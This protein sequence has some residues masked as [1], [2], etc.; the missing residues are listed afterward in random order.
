MYVPGYGVR[1]VHLVF[2]IPKKGLARFFANDD[3]PG[4]LV[5]N[6]RFTAFDNAPGV[7]HGMYH[8]SRCVHEENGSKFRLASIESRYGTYDAAA[9]CLRRE[10][11]Q[12]PCCWTRTEIRAAPKNSQE[13]AT[14]FTRLDQI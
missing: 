7:A 13:F 1:Q 11:I 3:D 9:T 12:Q 10:D 5:Y 4:C 2:R 8:V 14:P 6:E